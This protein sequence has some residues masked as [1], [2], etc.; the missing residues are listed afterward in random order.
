M[1]RRAALRYGEHLQ[2]L[3]GKLQRCGAS[4]CA[5]EPGTR[6]RQPCDWRSPVSL[7]LFPADYRASG[8]LLH[9]TSLPSP[10]G[11]GD[12]GPTA[13]AFIDALHD[14]GQRWW[15]ALPLGPTGYGDSPY[16]SSSSFAGNELL[17]SP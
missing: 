8:V 3:R 6:S 12:V 14:A 9:V 4:R 17:I 15:Q 16:Q 13:V 2:D 7:P 5:R 1:V 11:I 10:Y